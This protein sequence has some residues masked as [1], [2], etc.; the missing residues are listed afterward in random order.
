MRGRR[1]PARRASRAPA[2]VRG[3]LDDR[4]V[5]ARPP[6]GSRRRAPAGPRSGPGRRRA[7]AASRAAATVRGADVPGRALDVGERRRRAEVG[8]AVGA[9]R[10]RDRAR[11]AARRPGPARRRPPR[12]CSAGGAGGEGDGVGRVAARR[13]TPPR[14]RRPPAPAS[15]SRRAAPRRRRSTSCSSSDWRPYGIGIARHASRRGAALDCPH[16]SPRRPDGPQRQD[17]A[18]HRRDRL[19]RPRVHAHGARR[20]TTSR[21]SGSSAATSSSSPSSQRRFADDRLRL[22]LGDVRDRD[23]LRLRHPRRRRDRPRRG[24]QAGAGVRVQP[25]RGGADERAR[26]RERRSRRRSTT[27]SR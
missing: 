17:P 12:A 14:T 9:R 7:C 15:A 13:R 24:A 19:V 22:L 2:R 8:R 11:D 5:R 20:A 25:V 23:R 1:R 18:R 21:R 10:E 6:R 27:T 4:H 16:R 26:R 3:V